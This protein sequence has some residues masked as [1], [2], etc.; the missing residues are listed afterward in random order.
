MSRTFSGWSW[1]VGG[2]EWEHLFLEL[3]A[4]PIR[5]PADAAL[6]AVATGEVPKDTPFLVAGL[7]AMGFAYGGQRFTYLLT[8]DGLYTKVGEA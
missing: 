8:D 5:G 1:N 7:G 4:D 2:G 6:A 3:D